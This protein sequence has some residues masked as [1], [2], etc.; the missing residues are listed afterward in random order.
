MELRSIIP[1][2]FILLVLSLI[3]SVLKLDIIA[4]VFYSEKIIFIC[5]L[6]ILFFILILTVKIVVFIIFDFLFA[7]K[8]KIK[9]PRLIKDVVVILLYG[10]GLLFI[11]NYYLDIKIT[12]VLASSAVLTVVVGFALQDILGD[13]FSGIALN[14]EESL[15][16]GDWIS[17]GEYEG[18]IEQFRWR[19]IK[20][21]TIDNALVVIP[22]QIAAKQAVFCF[23]HSGQSFALRTTIGVSYENS[24][25]FVMETLMNV[26]TSIDL[27]LKLPGPKVFV[28]GFDDFAINYEL[29][30]FLRDFSNKS[31]I[32]GEIN[33]KSYYA[34]KRKDI[35]IPFPVRDVYIKK[36]A[37]EKH[38]NRDL[39]T[40]IK[41][42][43]IF[44]SIDEVQLKELLEDIKVEVFGHGELLIS[45]G[46][47]GRWFF[48]ILSGE[49]EIITNN[50]LLNR[51][52][53]NDYFGE[54]SL[55]TGEKTAASVRVSR[56]SEIIRIPSERFRETVKVNKNMAL[57]VSEVIAARKAKLEEFKEKESETQETSIRKETESLFLRIK[58]Y[59]SV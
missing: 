21:R 36:D 40:L 44:D 13:L 43:E 11:A 24:P 2:L 42:N 57:K 33:R 18:R 54:L 14:L 46:D 50:R 31:N 29:K 26:M 48:H 17:T 22:N 1:H 53:K 52:G 28:T 3:I 23:G 6:A 15:K 47:E 12:V 35:K 45:E 41:K 16:I 37:D 10:I 49:V 19:S 55:F 34:F 58:N 8:Q 39:V 27:I 5:L 20:L 4:R 25:D 38:A 7:Q 51:L 30:F 59:F 56:E 32:L 9:Y